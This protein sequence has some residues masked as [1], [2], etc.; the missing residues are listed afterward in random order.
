MI[1]PRTFHGFR[2][3]VSEHMYTVM[4]QPIVSLHD[5]E[6]SH[7]EWLV[8]FQHE[9]GVQGVIRPA[10]LSG[11]IKDLDLSMLARAVLTINRFPDGHG[12]AVNLSGASID[13][14]GFEHALMACLSALQGPAS[15]L[16]IELTETW[17]LEN[18]HK[19]KDILH[20]LKERGH[21]ICLDD[22]G[23]GAASIRYLRALPA[24]YL[25]IDGEFVVSAMNDE[26][27]RAI[28]EMLFTLR[29]SLGFKFIAEGVETDQIL[30]FVRKMEFDAVQGYG[31]GRPTPETRLDE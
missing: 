1:D 23:A 21:K 3:H 9:A 4:K 16:I 5:N 8:R 6:I 10:E 17:D 30:D 29:E 7:Y 15:K 11:A 19:A 14:P 27:E 24:D 26:R 22:V 28:L 20:K 2:E 12:M 18:L 13:L 25:K 31:I